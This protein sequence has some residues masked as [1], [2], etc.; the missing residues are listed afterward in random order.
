MSGAD[1]SPVGSNVISTPSGGGSMSGMGENFSPDLFTGTGNF[2]IPIAVL[3]GRNNLSPSISGA[4]STGNGNT[5]FGWGWGFGIPSITRQT[6]KGVPTYQED[7]D[8]FL[9]SGAEDLIEISKET[10]N[11]YIVRSYQPRTEG[12][13]ARIERYVNATSDFWKVWSKDGMISIYGTDDTQSNN[14]G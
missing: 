14:I 13:F 11:G 6:R 1:Q 2:S 5:E 9:L 12:L 3:P 10:R 7:E 4:Y 8:V